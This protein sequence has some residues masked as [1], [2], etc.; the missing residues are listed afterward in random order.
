M[1]DGVHA[2]VEATG[3]EVGLKLLRRDARMARAQDALERPDLQETPVVCKFSALVALLCC[4]VAGAAP[5]G[6]ESSID[7]IRRAVTSL[8]TPT[9]GG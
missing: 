9:T 4:S 7:G 5:V 6:V 8:T 1:A 3:K 2:R